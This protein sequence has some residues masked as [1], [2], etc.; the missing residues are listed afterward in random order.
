MGSGSRFHG[1]VG[2]G[3]QSCA[4][5]GCRAPGEFR[6]PDLEGRGPSPNGP[7]DYQWLC[8]DHV[9]EF[10]ARYDWFSGMS[11]EEIYAAQSPIHSWANE[12]RAFS[13]TAG[14]H[15]LFSIWT[16]R[17]EAQ[18]RHQDVVR[19]GAEHR[20]LIRRQQ[21]LRDPQ[22]LQSAARKLGMV[23]TGEKAYVV[24]GLPDTQR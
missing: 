5:R 24:T 23:H 10:N 16:A 8:L 6:A 12:T 2:S 7:G 1:A 22:A 21:A 11:A 18:R 15:P 4:A 19:L 17:G 9:R 13:A 20:A 3:E 14:I